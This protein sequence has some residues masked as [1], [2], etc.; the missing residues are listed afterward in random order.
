[1]A[2]L[3]G[4]FPQFIQGVSEQPERE[5]LDGQ[6]W[7]QINFQS[8]ALD[9]LRRRPGTTIR[10]SLPVALSDKTAC[11]TYYRGDTEAYRIYI[12]NGVIT[13]MDDCNGVSKTVHMHPGSAP[14]LTC[15]DPV[16][17]LSFLTVG[18]VTLVSNSKVVVQKS[19][20]KSPAR[21]NDAIVFVKH[22]NYGSQ[23]G[24][25]IDGHDAVHTTPDGSASSHRN[26]I[27]VSVIASNLEGKIRTA[28]G[29]GY[30][31]V[32]NGYVII[33]TRLDGLPM[34]VQARDGTGGEDM[35][36]FFDAVEY[37]S[38]L[39]PIG[40]EGYMVQVFGTKEDGTGSKR[41]HWLKFV[42][43]ANWAE[44]I[45]PNVSL[46]FDHNTMPHVLM[47]QSDGSFMFGPA[48]RDL[49][50]DFPGTYWV[51]RPV[52]DEDS[53]PN[54]SFVGYSINGMGLFQNRLLLLAD[55]NVVMT[56]TGAM[57]DFWRPSALATADDDPIDIASNGDEV[58]ELYSVT[59]FNKTLLLGSRR[60][61]FIIDGT[62]AVTPT[63]VAMP[64]ASAYEMSSAC[65][66]V[67]A[68]ASVFFPVD[69]GE[70]TGIREYFVEGTIGNNRA[71]SVTGHVPRYLKGRARKMVSTTNFDTLAVI[72]DS[73]L[74][75]VYIYTYVWQGEKKVLSSW[76][77]W[78]LPGD[79]VIVDIEMRDAFMHLTATRNGHTRV[80]RMDFSN[81][82]T[83]GIP[84]Q[85]AL[86][87][88][89]ELTTFEGPHG[90]VLFTHE[91]PLIKAE[92]ETM[93]IYGEDHKYIGMLASTVRVYDEMPN[94]W[95][96]VGE[97]SPAGFKLI[98]GKSFLS[99]YRL[100]MP[101]VKDNDGNIIDG[102]RQQMKRMLFQYADTG[103]FDVVVTYPSRQE[104]RYHFRGNV[105]GLNSLQVG[106]LN[107]QEGTFQVP[108][109]HSVQ[110]LKVAFE[111]TSYTPCKILHGQWDA[112]FRQRGQRV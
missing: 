90:E 71:D 105:I 77:E 58:T 43:N 108:I 44:T 106:A 64:M 12:S 46:G 97:K 76:S 37:Y 63:T 92:D 74:N 24:V 9:G 99:R 47:R 29:A 89:E 86:D 1:M 82:N 5:R 94:T 79:C 107:L 13:V 85:L 3:S 66:P 88:M 100:S 53:V 27:D 87:F 62:K 73:T 78:S 75:T 31:V 40:K 33:I 84:A 41:G 80:L 4:T 93:Y 22:G 45:G 67:A 36:V 52:G 10:Y 20:Q 95:Q 16:R 14:Y 104:Q 96:I 61:Q 54:P 48:D 28:L 81:P 2:R 72:T 70:F 68:G 34:K 112:N 18:D 26:A 32:R 69:Y 91:S 51:D 102:V 55:E 11:H 60:T 17:N 110:G 98:A 49:S 38:D 21:D 103:A 109:R 7:E 56:R 15:H 65:R 59:N 23:Y 42:G 35:A 50:E 57:F 19:A 8:S 30:T 83:F 25:T 39:P 111:T 101:Y 6:G